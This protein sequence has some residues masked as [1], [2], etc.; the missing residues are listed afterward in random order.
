[1]KIIHIIGEKPVIAGDLLVF[2]APRPLPCDIVWEGDFL[3][4]IFYGASKSITQDLIDM[5]A[6][7][8]DYYTVKQARD[9]LAE[10]YPT[11]I[12]RI[13]ALSTE[14]LKKQLDYT[15]NH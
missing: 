11:L 7:V 5:D 6:M 8:V 1:M 14:D 4:G 12:D 2:N 10:K 15:M 3:H 13:Y 9:V